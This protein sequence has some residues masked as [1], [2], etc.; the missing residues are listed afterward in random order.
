MSDRDLHLDFVKG[1]LVVVMVIYHTM[2]YFFTSSPEDFAYIRFVTGSFIFISGYIISA[3]YMKK[4]R[5]DKNRI[6][7]R[8][9][10][11]G[12]KLFIMFTVLNLSINLL[13]IENYKG[14]Q[15]GL[16][17][18]LNNIGQIY[19]SGNSRSVAFQ[20]L[21]PISYLLIVSTAYIIFYGF[22]KTTIALTLIL[23]FLYTFL[24]IDSYNLYLV[25]IGLVGLSV[26]LL[27]NIERAY[28]I[29]SK[30]IIFCCLSICLGIM[31]YLDRNIF[32]YSLGIIIVLKLIYD[33]SKTVN[34]KKQIFQL[35][36]LLG[37]YSL[38]SYIIQIVFLHLLSM[39][40]LKE[41]WE[42]G[43][44]IV[45]IFLVT[46]IFLLGICTSLRFLRYRYRLI[47]NSY[48]FFFA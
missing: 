40:L 31:G 46:N 39:L 44:E 11:R 19:I 38:V 4:Y 37:Q 30:F 45:S 12:L 25:L 1:V 47:D 15:F 48:K 13:A 32:L 28:S 2:N 23:T 14:V 7:L 35:I 20:I 10:V 34:L 22:K 9:I 33:F 36:I 41:R 5:M 43:Y 17:N 8:L 29:K 6:C 42:L 18:Y 26:G 24:N 16:Q 27:F 3:V 21:V